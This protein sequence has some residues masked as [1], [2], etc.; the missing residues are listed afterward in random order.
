MY[1]NAKKALHKHL[2]YLVTLILC[3][4]IPLLACENKENFVLAI[5][6]G[7]SPQRVGALSA[8]GR[9]EYYFNYDL[10]QRL[11]QQIEKQKKIQAF[12]ITANDAEM[13][14]N[15]RTA[16]A[17]TRD[18]NLLLSLHHDSAQ[19]HYLRTWI[20]QGRQQRY[21]DKFHG[22]SIFVSEDN[23][24]FDDSL[25][26]GR[27]LAHALQQR[28]FVPTLHHA[29]MIEGES[30]VLLDEFLGIYRFDELLILRHS[31]MPALL[32][33][34]GVIIHRDE[35]IL[36]RNPVYQNVLVA[37]ISEAVYHYAAH[38]CSADVTVP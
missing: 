15:V 35:E 13:E 27:Y 8:R 18:A 31:K 14:L 28:E 36:L 1:L 38:H 23:P 24:H 34:A 3:V 4:N 11:L 20:Y 12:I 30:R 2:F 32:L 25:L 16:L 17:N 37:A 9:G 22:Y 26:F 6:I 7:H 29:E 21:S 5:D 33:E 19:E 10:A